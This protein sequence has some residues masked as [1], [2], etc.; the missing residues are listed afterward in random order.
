MRP[1]AILGWLGITCGV[2]A[3]AAALLPVRLA[4]LVDRPKPIEQSVADRAKEIRDRALELFK[5]GE[6]PP[7]PRPVELRELA[8]ATTLTLGFVAF[9]LGVIAFVRHEPLRAVL[10]SAMLGTVAIAIAIAFE[11]F[12]YAI[13]ML[14]A[15]VAMMAVLGKKAP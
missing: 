2:L 3:L 12:S 9:V 13:V 5:R 14:V 10:A 8:S 1:R 15:V 11:A 6:V 7:K 4:P